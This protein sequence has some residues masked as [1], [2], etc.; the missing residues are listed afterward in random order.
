MQSGLG[1]F[2]FI[3]SKKKYDFKIVGFCWSNQRFGIYFHNHK[4]LYRRKILKAWTFNPTIDKFEG[5]YDF[6]SY[7]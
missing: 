4:I 5:L 3:I 7:P 6:S 2:T 1:A